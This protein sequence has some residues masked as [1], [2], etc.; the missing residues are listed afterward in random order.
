M[1]QGSPSKWTVS[2]KMKKIALTLIAL[3]TL[4]CT[5]ALAEESKW[6]T[7]LP[8]A[9]KQ[10]KAE[11]KLVLIDF[12]GSDWCGWCI[13][14][15]KDTLDTPEFAKYAKENLVLVEL[16]FPSKKEQPAELKKTNKELQ[17]KY[18]VSGFPTLV[19]L[20]GDGKEVGRQTGYLKGGPSA[21]V[22]K[23]NGYKAGK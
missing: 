4:A 13:K 9:L 1:N 20:D 17:T 22:E 23:L 19:V 8:A 21:F 2:H 16:D 6:S 11:K 12:T 18:K 7:D 3:A 15:K 14:F 10:A 5:T